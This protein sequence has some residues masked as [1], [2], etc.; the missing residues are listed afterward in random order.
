[1]SELLINGPLLYCIVLYL[2]FII[3]L[4]LLLLTF[5]TEEREETSNILRRLTGKLDEHKD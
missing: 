1:M 2:P 3:L 4:K 5:S